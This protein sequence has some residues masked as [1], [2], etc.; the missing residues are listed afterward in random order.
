M[1]SQTRPKSLW[2]AVIDVVSHSPAPPYEAPMSERLEQVIRHHV[3]EEEQSLEAYRSVRDETGDPV[4]RMLMEEVLVDERHHHALLERLK[5]QFERELDPAAPGGGLEVSA[6]TADSTADELAA[7]V[8]A[9]A[10]REGA[11]VRRLREL[12]KQY[13]NVYSGLFSLILEGIA[14]DSAKHER[15][16]RFA[17]KRLK[18]QE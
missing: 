15:V 17:A 5:V 2:E 10:G 14:S 4:V 12:A 9:L 8:R 6:P 18:V 3:Q 1:S 16:L 7:T 13:K 11:G